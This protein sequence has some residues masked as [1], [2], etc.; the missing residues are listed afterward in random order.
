MIT[1]VHIKK[2]IFFSIIKALN[3]REISVP[4]WVASHF[5]NMDKPQSKHDLK[6]CQE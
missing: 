4:A 5:N 6:R 1:L 3:W 2:Q